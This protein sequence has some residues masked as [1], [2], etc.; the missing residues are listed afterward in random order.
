MQKLARLLVLATC[1]GGCLELFAQENP[2][3]YSQ[4]WTLGLANCCSNNDI[5]QTIGVKAIREDANKA[6]IKLMFSRANESESGDLELQLKQV[7]NMLKNEVKAVVIVF[8]QGSLDNHVKIMAEARAKNIPV[9]AYNRNHSKLLFRDFSNLYVVSSFAEQAGILQANMITE[10][11]KQN[12][13]WDKNQD[14]V[15][16][17]AIIRGPD[18]NMD[19][20]NRTKWVK[21]TL[22]E[23]SPNSHLEVVAEESANWDDKFRAKE[24]I[25]SWKKSGVLDKVEVIACNN[26]FLA[27]AALES[28]QENN[29]NLPLFGID[30]LR[31]TIRQIAQG[32]IQ[33]TIYQDGVKQAKVAFRIARNLV[34][35]KPASTNLSDLTFTDNGRRVMIPYE[36]ITKS[37]VGKYQ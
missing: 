1:F 25:A 20:E 23:S 22:S 7:R 6:N 13:D 2:Q 36:T 29:L 11:W 8:A 5:F 17:M 33:G 34:D 19:A 3:G 18:G 31:E 15:V 24:I 26:D 32:N 21:K 10:L 9:V 35:G 30:G 12:P 28:L 37:N 14:G 16:Q 27:L 4:G